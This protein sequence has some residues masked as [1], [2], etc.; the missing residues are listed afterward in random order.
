MTSAKSIRIILVDTNELVREGLK[1]FI[2]VQD[3]MAFI[4]EAE[5]VSEAIEVCRKLQPDIVLMNPGLSEVKGENTILLLKKI[6][7][8]TRIVILTSRSEPEFIRKLVELGVDG[9]LSKDS[10]IAVLANL[11]YRVYMGE[12][13]YGS[14]IQHILDNDHAPHL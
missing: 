3:S 5:N 4:G 7:P 11:I 2:E 12:Q 1:V 6:S 9:L 14:D 8:N 13:V 10:S